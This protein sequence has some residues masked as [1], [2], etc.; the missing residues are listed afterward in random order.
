MIFTA[1]GIVAAAGIAAGVLAAMPSSPPPV[2]QPTGLT[3]AS[4]TT[5]AV[6]LTWSGPAS[7]PQP[8][9][10]EILADGKDIGSVPGNTTTYSI[11]QLNPATPYD[12]KVVA[13]RDGTQSAASA[14]LTARTQ[15]PPLSAAM[16][17]WT[18]TMTWKMTAL[19]PPESS[20][21]KQ[22]GDSWQDSW[23]F[24]PTSCSS[25]SC[26][27]RL[28]GSYVNNPFAIQLT[29]S[30]AT[31]SGS[32][33]LTEPSTCASSGNSLLPTTMN[34]SVTVSAAH[35]AGAQWTATAFSGT[36]ELVISPAGAC[37]GTIAQYTIT[38]GTSG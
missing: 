16:L 32:G 17:N 19:E 18:G 22:P 24:S 26:D 21:D 14:D 38:S 31:Y 15:T 33:P 2:L 12:F 30:G 10:Y 29:R 36:A 7:G 13:M 20:W 1:G 28:T 23:S 4:E 3:A 5:S 34:V 9:S 6:V 25:G 35:A 8:D 37:H 11:G 27:A